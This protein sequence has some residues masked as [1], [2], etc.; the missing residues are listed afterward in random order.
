MST[1]TAKAELAKAVEA[2]DKELIRTTTN[3]LAFAILKESKGDYNTAAAQAREI[4]KTLT[5]SA[6]W[7]AEAEAKRV[8]GMESYR[9]HASKMS[10]I[11]SRD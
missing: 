8:A 5:K 9:A 1:E 6:S 10:R 4:A 2:N 11:M 7:Y 3:A